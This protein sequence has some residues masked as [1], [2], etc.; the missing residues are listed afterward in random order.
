MKI[1]FMQGRLVKSEHGKIQEFPFSEWEKELEIAN[2]IN[3]KLIEWILDKKTISSNPFFLNTD[4]VKGTLDKYEIQVGSLSDDFFLQNE[5]SE[6]A[7]DEILRHLDKVFIKMLELN[8]PLYVFPLLEG[9]SLKN[10]EVENQIILLNKIEKLVPPN[11]KVCLETDLDYKNINKIF[12][13]IDTKIFRINYDIGNSAYEGYDYLE[14]F[15]NYFN[16][17]ENIHVKDRLYKGETVPLGKGDGNILKVIG[18]LKKRGYKKN[19][20]LQAA[21]IAGVDDVEVII[22]YREIVEEAIA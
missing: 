10:I 21:R 20:I 6:I 14:E 1:G 13:S 5:S 2:K 22:N 15:D 11:I 3:L 7:S 16:L 4:Y 17:I 18:E 8:I 19:L 9:K 12:E